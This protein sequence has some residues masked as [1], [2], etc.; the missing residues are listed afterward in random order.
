MKGARY[1]GAKTVVFLY[2]ALLA[3]A[4]VAW[5]SGATGAVPGAG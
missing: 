2:L 5:G 1:G 4:E 3:G